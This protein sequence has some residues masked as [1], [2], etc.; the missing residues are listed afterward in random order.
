MVAISSK[1]YV[2]Y[3]AGDTL[4]H[5][6]DPRTKIIMLAYFVGLALLFSN[7]LHLALV[8]LATFLIWTYARIPAK[9]ISRVY[10]Y[11]YGTLA[12]VIL[13]QGL[14]FPSG[15][16]IIRVIPPNP[17]IG[18]V[19]ALTVEGLAYGVAISE[20]ILIMMIIG[21]LVIYTTPLDR[22][23]LGLVKLKMPYSIA[24]I[25]SSAL[26]ILPSVQL[27]IE[28]IIEAQ[29]A[30]AFTKLETG[31]FVERMRAY[32]PILVPLI[33]GMAR[34]S[35]QLSLAMAA[36]AFGASKERTYY[37]DIKATTKD[38]IAISLM[39]ISFAI[40]VYLYIMYGFGA[41]NFKSVYISSLLRL[42]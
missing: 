23:I 9:E 24:Y 1:G 39:I 3:F 6:F 18:N 14:S 22:L 27:E 25:M 36:R 38:Y 28:T 19:G 41:F 42:F 33:V 26:N 2:V 21:P 12:L 5:K 8:I 32:I 15:T 29:T 20:R 37:H 13:I 10:R 34:N 35:T 16:E 31:G 4:I 7:P 17:L 40:F 30:R 11:V